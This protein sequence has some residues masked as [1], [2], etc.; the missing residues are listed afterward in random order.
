MI[1]FLPLQQKRQNIM[2]YTISNTVI[3]NPTKA[4]INRLRKMGIEKAKRL[5]KIQE[6]WDNGEYDNATV[7]HV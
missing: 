2:A 4:C 6:R 5:A 3:K 7:I 1:I